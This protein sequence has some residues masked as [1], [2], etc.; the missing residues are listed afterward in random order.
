MQKCGVQK[1]RRDTVS[2]SRFQRTAQRI[3]IIVS[4]RRR[5]RRNDESWIRW[6][7]RKKYDLICDDENND[8]SIAAIIGTDAVLVAG[9]LLSG[10]M[11]SLDGSLVDGKLVT[12]SRD[13]RIPEP[14]VLRPALYNEWL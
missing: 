3:A 14:K 4:L 13:E 6:L 10:P 2:V 8:N 11:W 5:R 1:Q 9:T 7:E 12:R